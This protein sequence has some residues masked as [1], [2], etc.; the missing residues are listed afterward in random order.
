M[1][2]ILCDVIARDLFIEKLKSALS[3]W[4]SQE[5]VL[6]REIQNGRL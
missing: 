1:H 6:F 5:A 4:E 3:G 2:S